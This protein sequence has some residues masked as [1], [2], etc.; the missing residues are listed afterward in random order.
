MQGLRIQYRG[1]R[2][3]GE[4]GIV[5]MPLIPALEVKSE[6]AEL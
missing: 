3:G 5:R 4:A 2:K 1:V 6:G